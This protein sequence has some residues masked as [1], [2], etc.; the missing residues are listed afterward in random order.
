MQPNTADKD[1]KT[2]GGEGGLEVSLQA[3]ASTL[4]VT[5]G[6]DIAFRRAKLIMHNKGPAE[7]EGFTPHATL[8][9]ER[10]LVHDATEALSQSLTA[11]AIPAGEKVEWDIYDLLLSIHGGVASK[12]HLWGYKAILDWW[13]E[14]SA[15]AE[16]RHPDAALIQTPVFRWK[17]KWSP[18]NSEAEEI[19]LSIE[20]VKD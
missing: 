19:G 13:L 15:W 3:V 2:P 1:T 11:Q 14:L 10:G 8:L 17:L 16:Y 18:A 5:G 20:V 9:Q 12:V 4:G 6:R 7:V